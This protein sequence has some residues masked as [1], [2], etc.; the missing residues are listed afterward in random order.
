MLKDVVI[1]NK[2]YTK[3]NI[4]EGR[5]VDNIALM[6]MKQDCPD[7]L[8]P[9]KTLEIDGELE[10]R[11][12]LLEGIR[13]CYSNMKMMKN[14]FTVLLKNMLI[15]FK[16]CNDWFLDYHNILMDANYIMVGRNGQTVRYI[17]IPMAEYAH[18][19]RQIID[20]FCD[21]VLKAEIADDPR[22][23]VNLLRVLKADDANLMTLLDY[24]SKETDSGA[25]EPAA[26]GNPSAV[27]QP[28]EV[29]PCKSAVGAAINSGSAFKGSTAAVGGGE[30][31]AQKMRT[32]RTEETETAEEKNNGGRESGAARPGQMPQE[33]G[34]QDMEARLLGNLF[35]DDEKEDDQKGD[36]Q[37]KKKK[38]KDKASKQTNEVKGAKDRKGL[39]FFKGNGKGEKQQDTV[40]NA[41]RGASSAVQSQ[42]AYTGAENSAVQDGWQSQSGYGGEDATEIDKEDE[43]YDSSM[44]RLSLENGAGFH[45]PQYIEINLQ[46][47][48][49]TVGRYDKNGQAQADFNFDASLSFVSRVHFRIEKIGEQWQ[50]IDLNSHNGTFVNGEALIPNIAYPLRPNDRI[51]ISVKNRLTYQV[52]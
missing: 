3:L 9:L 22:Y 13:L 35:G 39:F 38:K 33:F 43:V 41:G 36:D 49:A 51:M 8:L 10:L 32:V 27:N 21:I 24:I 30:Q 26:S 17:Y 14:E 25:G 46:K 11:Y 37:A 5:A 31:K 4:T 45:C 15:P 20:F 47:G 19:D 40:R 7:F 42:E 44:I 2:S 48:F 23:T 12:E 18:S 6:V 1:A 34:R 50:I 28:Q 29:Q 52:C 16:T